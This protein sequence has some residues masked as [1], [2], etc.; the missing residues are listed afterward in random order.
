MTKRL[1]PASELHEKWMKKPNYA[2]A[3][4]GMEEEF[5]LAS[6]LI[7]ARAASGLTQE[8]VAERM[9]TTRTAIA[10]LE[11]GQQMPSTRTL[12]RFAEATGHRLRITLEPGKAAKGARRSV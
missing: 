12:S 4:V 6:A 5:A 10:R 8:Q 1:T 7:K 3:F 2:E 11:S 9:N